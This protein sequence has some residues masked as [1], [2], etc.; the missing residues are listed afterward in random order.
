M[1]WFG[2]FLLG[3]GLVVYG[4]V[5]ALRT[6]KPDHYMMGGG[7][8]AALG[9]IGFD[10][11][12]AGTTGGLDRSGFLSIVLTVGGVVAAVWALY[13]LIWSLRT[14]TWPAT[15]GTV[16]RSEEELLQYRNEAARAS[17]MKIRHAW[18]LSYTYSVDGRS[19]TSDQR[20]LDTDEEEMDLSAALELVRKHPVGS[21]ITVYHHPKDPALACIDRSSFNGRWLMPALFAAILVG[22]AQFL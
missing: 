2:L 1:I 16:E 9:F 6:R 15:E 19:Y 21:H 18:R 5:V 3:L 17:A 12:P 10:T 14:L 4:L 7:F 13:Q 8:L 22:V 20:G 11:W